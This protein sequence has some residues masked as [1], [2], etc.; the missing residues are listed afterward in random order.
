MKTDPMNYR[1]NCGILQ[2]LSIACQDFE[3]F[4]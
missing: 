2:A 4:Y 1:E 3:F